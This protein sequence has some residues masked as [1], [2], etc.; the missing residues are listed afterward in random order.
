[1]IRNFY[2]AVGE[3]ILIELGAVIVG[4]GGHVVNDYLVGL[5]LD[6]GSL[7]GV[8]VGGDE[9]N[10][11]LV[12]GRG[13]VAGLQVA[14]EL[15][16]HLLHHRSYRIVEYSRDSVDLVYLLVV[17]ALYAA[18]ALVVL[19]VK[20]YVGLAVAVLYYVDLEVID[21]LGVGDAEAGIC[22][23]LI[24]L[25]DLG[26]YGVVSVLAEVGDDVTD[27]HNAALKGGG[28]DLDDIALIHVA[29][30]Y[31]SVERGEIRHIDGSVL[32][33]LELAVMS[34]DAVEGV[35]RQVQRKKTVKNA[36]AMDVMVE[37]SAGLGVIDLADVSL[38]CVA[39][40]RVSDVVAESDSLDQV[41]VEAEDRA[42]GARK[43]RHKL[44]VKRA[45]GDIVVLI[46]GEHLGLVGVSVVKGA[47]HYLVD[48]AHISR[49]PDRRNVGVGIAADGGRILCREVGA[50]S[51]L[52]VV[53][54]SLGKLG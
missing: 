28:N 23:D 52:K 20:H 26:A 54:Y 3:K 15:V 42:D 14:E 45:A 5:S 34:D 17:L 16:V 9:I 53:F 40:G 30:L 35:E 44:N 21:D 1:M 51:V 41:E 7:R 8:V 2:I 13:L 50:S 22:R 33:H 27:A 10:V 6:V 24:G 39:E 29:A 46:E 36:D 4:H 11:M 38:A 43:S 48:V 32:V 19:A 25:C 31:H 47:I 49:T 37:I 18:E 12:D